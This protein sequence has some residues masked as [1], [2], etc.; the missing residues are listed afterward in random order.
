MH[1]F[2]TTTAEQVLELGKRAAIVEIEKPAPAAE[3][4]VEKPK[5]VR[6]P[7]KAKSSTSPVL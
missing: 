6:R 1:L 2:A 7:R 5:P 4:P 3:V